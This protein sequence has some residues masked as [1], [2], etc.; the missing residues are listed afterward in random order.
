MIKKSIYKPFCLFFSFAILQIS[1]TKD[2]SEH[3]NSVDEIS[4]EK[5]VS[6]IAGE[7][8]EFISLSKNF[9]KKSTLI[10]LSQFKRIL[11]SYDSLKTY[12][13]N[14]A[15]LV[16]DTLTKIR[17]RPLYNQTKILSLI[18]DDAGPKPAGY[19]HVQF[20]VNSP[21]NQ[22]SGGLYVMHLYF[23]TDSYGRVI[24]NPSIIYTGIGYSSW[25]QSNVSAISYNGNSY[26]SSFNITGMNTYGIQFGSFTLGWSSMSNFLIT[27]NMDEAATKQVTIIEQR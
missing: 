15:E 11:Q 5:S 25:E 18:D 4:A 3:S 8:G 16:I 19:Y 23:S 27:I 10:N 26:T 9:F 13:A 21:I 22:Y 24:G 12:Q 2:M 6:E 1:C 14:V 17:N 7:K 20:P